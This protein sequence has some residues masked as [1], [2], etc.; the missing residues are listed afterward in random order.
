MSNTVFTATYDPEADALAIDLEA[1]GPR[2]S[3]RTEQLDERRFVD[4]DAT[5]RIVSIELLDVSGGV[6]FDGLPDAGLVRGVV[7]RLASDQGW[8]GRP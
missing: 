3:A 6:V 2:R 5:G 7:E 1:S 4:Y 8:A